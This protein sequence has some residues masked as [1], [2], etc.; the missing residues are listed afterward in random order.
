LFRMYINIRASNLWNEELLKIRAW[1]ESGA[2][3]G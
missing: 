3:Q 2:H 1:I